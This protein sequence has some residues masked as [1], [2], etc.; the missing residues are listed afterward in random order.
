[1]MQWFEKHHGDLTPF[2]SWARGPA[3]DITGKMRDLSRL[4]ESLRANPMLNPE[5]LTSIYGSSKWI[6]TNFG[7]TKP[8]CDMD[9]IEKDSINEIRLFL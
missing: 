1:M 3:A 5:C 4:V 7:N 2:V 9:V 8:I 6:H